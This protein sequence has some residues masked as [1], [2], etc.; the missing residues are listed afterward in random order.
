MDRMSL[1]QSAVSGFPFGASGSVDQLA[2]HHR[3]FNPGTATGFLRVVF[4]GV[5]THDQ[6]TISIIAERPDGTFDLFHPTLDAS[7]V[8]DFTV[9]IPFET[10]EYVG[11]IVTNSKRTGGAQPYDLS[12]TVESSVVS[13]P[14]VAAPAARLELAPATPNPFRGAT[15]FDYAVPRDGAIRIDVYD[16]AGRRV[17]NL[18]DGPAPAGPGV[19]TWDGTDSAGRPVPT[20]VYWARLVGEDGSVVRKATKLR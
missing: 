12:V 10:L 13:A 16:V 3:R 2:A 1:F 15:R 4:D 7:Q 18:V 20:G 11:V 19:V 8:A 6:W 9:S 17:R 5:D 14:A